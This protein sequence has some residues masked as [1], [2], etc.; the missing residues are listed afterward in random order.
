MA[1]I[2]F[3]N[4]ATIKK[5]AEWLSASLELLKLHGEI[6]S[7]KD[8]VAGTN[9]KYPNV[10]AYKKGSGLEPK[11]FMKYFEKKYGGKLKELAGK[12]LPD[13]TGT[14]Q[15]R[16]NRSGGSRLAA[17]NAM[18]KEQNELL[19][20]TIGDLRFTIELLKGKN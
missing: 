15:D 2:Q 8:V 17:E 3:V 4:M 13:N 1:N 12:P 20:Q 16:E 11:G 9:Y 19:K 7:Y 6:K 10:S 18:L 14:K 5:S